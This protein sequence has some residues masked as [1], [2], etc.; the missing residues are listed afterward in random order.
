MRVA[1]NVEQETKLRITSVNKVFNKLAN[2]T[3]VWLRCLDSLYNVTR[4]ETVDDRKRLD[5]CMN[6]QKWVK[7]C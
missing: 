4:D 7:L 6:A 1:Y 2:R 5:G 3:L